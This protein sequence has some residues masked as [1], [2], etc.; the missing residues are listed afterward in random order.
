MYMYVCVCGEGGLGVSMCI[1]AYAYTH[2]GIR[3][4]VC[5]RWYFV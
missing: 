3:T 1:G 5:A 4:Y 2:E